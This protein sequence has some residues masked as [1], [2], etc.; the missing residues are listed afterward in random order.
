[1]ETPALCS[2]ATFNLVRESR[3]R[4]NRLFRGLRPVS[5]ADL[6]GIAQ[7]GRAALV[8]YQ[9]L[10]DPQNCPAIRNLALRRT[11]LDLELRPALCLQPR[12]YLGPIR[13][14]LRG[15]LVSV[16]VDDHTPHASHFLGAADRTIYVGPSRGSA[17][18]LAMGQEAVL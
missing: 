2:R 8:T 3:F 11:G 12:R 10:R 16:P 17:V 9:L 5:A 18:A 15:H 14:D 7:E 4:D 1:M 13:A 6:M